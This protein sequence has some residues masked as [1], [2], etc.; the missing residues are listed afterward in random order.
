M[1]YTFCSS[2][3]NLLIFHFRVLIERHQSGKIIRTKS[4]QKPRQGSEPWRPV[5][6]L[7]QSLDKKSR[8]PSKP[9]QN[10]N[11]VKHVD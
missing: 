8:N 7:T 1:F 9:K 6:R 10:F 2:E 5:G 11:A 4:P 3:S